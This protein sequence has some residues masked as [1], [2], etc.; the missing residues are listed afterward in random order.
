MSSHNE[1]AKQGIKLLPVGKL[2][3]GEAKYI[4]PLY[5]RNYAWEE[6]EIIQ[7]I[8]D[9][10]DY[11]KD[12]SKDNTNYHIGTLVVFKK[13]DETDEI[14]ETIDGQQ[15]L[16][17][18]FLLLS[19]LQ[20][21][22]KEINCNTLD[23]ELNESAIGFECRPRSQRTLAKIFEGKTAELCGSQEINEAILNGYNIIESTLPKLLK[24]SSLKCEKFC[25]FLFNQVQ[26]IRVEVPQG[27]D[28]NHY[29]EI[30]NSR[31]EQ[32]EQHE[33]IKARMLGTLTDEAERKCFNAIWE[34]CA[35]MEKYVQTAF[36]PGQRTEIFGAN[37]EGLVIE[38]F[39]DLNS[40]LQG[41]SDSEKNTE[42]HDL[43]SIIG[44]QPT[45]S[46]KNSQPPGSKPEEEKPDRFSSI[47]N[48]SNFLL[49][50]LR[51]YMF[52][53]AQKNSL[54]ETKKLIEDIPLD[55]KRLI[56]TFEDNILK[57]DG[58]DGKARVKEFAFALLR[59][60]F[61]YDHY[62]IKR[63]F[64]M[65]TNCQDKGC[66]SLKRMKKNETASYVCTFNNKDAEDEFDGP[67]N[68][69]ILMLQAAFH[70]SA[71]TQNYK[72][73]LGAALNYLFRLPGAEVE[74][75]PYLDYLEGVAKSFMFDRF[76]SAN[77]M[78]YYDI[79]YKNHE[80]LCKG[81]CQ[82][83]KNDINDE[84]LL[85]GNIA[86]NFVF[87]YLDYLL[88]VKH[89]NEDKVKVFEFTFRSSVEH[90]YPQN[91]ELGDKLPPNIID[92][93]GNLC[94]ISHSRNSQ[95]GNRPPK[96]KKEF[97]TDKPID[98]VKQYLMMK[99]DVW[100]EK[101]INEHFDEMRDVLLGA[102]E[103]QKPNSEEEKQ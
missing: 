17:T 26:I 94:L 25:T 40:I 15:R 4:I 77:N 38:K 18:L 101:C 85:F 95:L 88:W 27:T 29:F 41:Q 11:T 22:K 16:T 81:F 53:E 6:G 2:L 92:S 46:E 9:I 103:G 84:L 55:D 30:M 60:K 56:K 28:L 61:L 12:D 19:C 100:D 99:A 37:W 7:L 98:S 66:W 49:Q 48:F 39:S 8:Q 74:V 62:I 36:L 63:D 35:N 1:Q 80:D 69:Q 43:A 58:E 97:Y 13:Q 93:F 64:D 72:Y 54:E 32:L 10:I 33:I 86:N 70:V 24:E 79:I 34:A 78:D 20:N 89:K 45:E 91:P 14:Y 21:S 102:L 52:S 50:V 44:S 68:K 73:W 83:P 57:G 75:T 67:A 96:W 5:Q 23:V 51:V 87:N 59:C 76:L 82:A 71:P 42:P 31:G 65:K 90:H 47:I 3:N